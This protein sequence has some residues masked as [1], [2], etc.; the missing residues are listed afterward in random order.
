MSRVRVSCVRY[1]SSVSSLG[2]PFFFSSAVQTYCERYLDGGGWYLVWK[3]SYLQVAVYD[4][5]LAATFST[6][7]KPCR[8]LSDG[9]C[10]VPDK[11]L[12][13]ATEQMIASYHKGTVI[14]AYK[15]P[16]NPDLGKTALGVNLM[17]GWSK[18]VDKCTTNEGVRPAASWHRGRETVYGLA[19]DKTTPDDTNEN[20]DTVSRG[21]SE[22]RWYDC[23]IPESIS[24]RPTGTQMTI[25]IF[26]R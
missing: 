3:H 5:P 7:N 19:F 20:C 8:D 18:V 16:L 25:A 2:E 24:V 1:T 13:A 4:L 17:P 21:Y 9:W 6:V 15:S 23:R 12:Y 14:Y 11:Q 10:N 22:C 26:V